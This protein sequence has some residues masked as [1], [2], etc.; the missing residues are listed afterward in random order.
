[1]PKKT[2]CRKVICS[3]LLA[4]LMTVFTLGVRTPFVFAAAKSSSPSGGTHVITDMMGRKVTL[5]KEI[6]SIGTFT[7]IGVLNGFVMLM[8]DGNKLANNLSPSFTKTDKWKYEYIFVPQLAQKP[9]F[10]DA[11]RAVLMEV[12]LANRPDV[13]LTMFKEDVDIL[14]GRGLDAVYLS[15]KNADDAK[16]CINL[17]GVILNK[18]DVAAKYTKYFDGMVK[19]A[20]GIVKDIPKDKRKTVLYG[21]IMSFTQPHIIAEW[22][23]PKAGGIS[24]TDNGRKEER[25]TYTFEDL[26]KWNPDVI[27]VADKKEISDMKADSR[28]NQLKAVK[29]NKLFLAPTVAHT[30]PNRTIEQPLMIM[31]TLNKLYPERYSDEALA[32]DIRFFYR[33]FFRFGLSDEQLREISGN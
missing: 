26:L 18:Q 21:N 4:A 19:K 29:E 5:P 2:F 17:L 6:K 15:W 23:I 11:D 7:A 24:V 16:N 3:I 22:W 10:Q 12:V 27:I 31:W 14:Q 30:W 32:K 9:V 28:M 25:F 20:E 13:C 1:M 33:E 8:G